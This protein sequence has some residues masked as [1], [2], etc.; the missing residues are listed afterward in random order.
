MH[1]HTCVTFVQD[2]IQRLDINPNMI[3]SAT[4]AAQEGAT[5]VTAV[6]AEAVSTVVYITYNYMLSR[7]LFILFHIYIYN[8]H[9]IL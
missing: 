6:V 9:L 1:A 7:A 5:V 2:F 8:D 4:A 3:K